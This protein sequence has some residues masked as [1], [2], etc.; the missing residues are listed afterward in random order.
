MAEKTNIRKVAKE[1]GVSPATVSRVLSGKVP[2]SDELA[3]RVRS[4]A[5][6]LGYGETQKTILYIVPEI[7]NTY[8]SMDCSGILENAYRLGYRVLFAETRHDPV[9]E[10]RALR[11]AL[12]PDISGTIYT[13]AS[14]REPFELV[15]EL[16]GR[17][18]I[19][20]A[21][22]KIAPEVPHIF[23]NHEEAAY[24][25]TRYLISLG[26]TRIAFVCYFWHDYDHSY[27]SFM[28]GYRSAGPGCFSV[29]DRFRGYMRALEEAG[30]TPDPRLIA[31]GG[32]EYESGR[33][34]ARQLV[35]S[36]VPFDSVLTPND[37]CGAGVLNFLRG[38]DFT[39]PEQ[40]SVCCLNSGPVAKAAYPALT[41]VESYDYDL[42]FA[43][44]SLLDKVIH[45]EKVQD[46]IL[47]IRLS[48]GKSTRKL[49]V[50]SKGTGA[51]AS[52]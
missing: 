4:A 51:Q 31:F 13:S 29:Y 2:V 12:A 42:G 39:V 46:V 17:P 14:G 40:V 26:R 1:A 16:K 10:E 38:Q 9:R 43:A 47:D 19:V 21:A 35:S 48:I 52:S 44:M 20:L 41:C 37:R 25:C 36:A 18:F 28:E 23:L 32:M 49:P 22:Q 24:M 30:I 34:A 6:R 11:S 33:E 45:G 50:D 7:G 8:Y 15:P 5:L 27:E 3:A